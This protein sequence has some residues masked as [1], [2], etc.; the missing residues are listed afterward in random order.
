MS[1]LS[2]SVRICPPQNFH[3]GILAVVVV[4][5]AAGSRG[6]REEGLLILLVSLSFLSSSSSLWY[7]VWSVTRT[8]D[9]NLA[10]RVQKLIY[11]DVNLL[12][13]QSCAERNIFSRCEV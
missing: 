3:F 8:M 6:L 10:R 5:V 9:T 7:L 2:T 13:E 4:L 1:N 11:G 12:P